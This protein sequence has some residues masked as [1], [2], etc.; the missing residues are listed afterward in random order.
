MN[1]YGK[2]I[3]EARIKKGYTQDQLAEKLFVTKQ[4]ISKYE[5]NHA[6]AS[7]DIKSKLEEL[8]DI[9]LPNHKDLYI[10]YKKRLIIGFSSVILL[11]GLGLLMLTFKMSNNNKVY[12]EKVTQYEELAS[13]Y[14]SLNQ[15]YQHLID[16]NQALI[17]TY[18]AIIDE[19]QQLQSDYETIYLENQDFLSQ[20]TLDFYG[21]SFTYKDHDI[22]DEGDLHID[23]VIHNSTDLVYQLNLDL[24]RINDLDRDVSMY[25]T[26]DDTTFGYRL[27]P[28][29]SYNETYNCTL[30]VKVDTMDSYFDSTNQVDLY[31]SEQFITR[32]NLDI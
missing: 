26:D 20:D 24:F 23:M 19:N 25:L 1:K 8:L 3:K 9:K 30:I 21:I 16:D 5:N 13:D 4:S 28:S 29:V 10:I 32:M 2:K 7:E 22:S 27:Y 11:L 17:N 12:Q 18:D 15:Q 14:Q 6:E 31:F